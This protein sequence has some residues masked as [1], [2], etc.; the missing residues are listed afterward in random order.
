[1]RSALVALALSACIPLDAREGELSPDF[2]V[3][4]HRG[5]PKHQAENTLAAFADAV[6]LGA[7]AI[8]A[9]VCL[10]RDGR[11]VVWHDADPDDAIALARKSGIE[12]LRYVP[13][14]P[15]VGSSLRRPVDALDAADFLA[16]H[17][18]AETATTG[19]DPDA[20]IATL[21][22]LARWA[23]NEPRLRTVFIDVKLRSATQAQALTAKVA[24]AFQDKVVF[25]SPDPAMVSALRDAT[26]FPVMLDA[27][28]DGALHLAKSLNVR[29]VA[30][31]LTP[32]RSERSF[33]REVER[34]VAARDRG[35]IDSVVVWTLDNPIQQAALLFRGVDGIMTN[36][37]DVL[38]ELWRETA[39]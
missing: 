24:E 9:D 31:G 28:A 29:H 39:E 2:L 18:Y 15:N 10:T 23:A 8:E 22:D 19:R 26:S 20:P 4:G 34:L 37:P 16:S 30:T 33:L 11:V 7:N 1:M 32:S 13:V 17:G 36:E 14:F 25:L 21:E 38:A 5:A 12:N 27:T 3:I 6:E 35:E